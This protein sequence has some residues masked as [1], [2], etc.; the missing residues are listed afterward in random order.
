M[1]EVAMSEPRDTAKDT[2]PG[3]ADVGPD[4]DDAVVTTSERGTPAAASG[5]ADLEGDT[6]RAGA[7]STANDTE[8]NGAAT[9]GS[10]R[11]MWPWSTTRR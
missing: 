11:Q 8:V 3:A 1:R 5:A 9:A 6:E 2:A 7:D 4:T 10:K